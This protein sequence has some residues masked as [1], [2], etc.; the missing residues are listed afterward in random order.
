MSR[1]GP[2]SVTGSG[3]GPGGP[4]SCPQRSRR[5]RRVFEMEM[6]SWLAVCC[7]T[8]ELKGKQLINQLVGIRSKPTVQRYH[9]SIPPPSLTEH[10]LKRAQIRCRR[11]GEENRLNRIRTQVKQ[12]AHKTRG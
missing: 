12:R 6:S 3:P 1:P 5:V 2:N 4:S 10:A 7:L 9:C 8:S 11:L